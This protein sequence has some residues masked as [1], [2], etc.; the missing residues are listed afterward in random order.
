MFQVQVVSYNCLYLMAQAS[1]LPMKYADT[2]ALK[3]DKKLFVWKV[4]QIRPLLIS[5]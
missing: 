5:G 1:H 2:C 3:Q 4:Q